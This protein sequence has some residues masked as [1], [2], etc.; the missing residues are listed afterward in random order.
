MRKLIKRSSIKK[1]AEN[2]NVSES[3][4]RERL[5]KYGISLQPPKAERVK[6]LKKLLKKYKTGYRVAKVL[7]V[8]PSTVYEKVHAY[9]LSL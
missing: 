3:L 8:T 9:G 7:K 2:L 5:K 4:I 6:D 1:I